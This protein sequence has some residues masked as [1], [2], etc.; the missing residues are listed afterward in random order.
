M[1]TALFIQLCVVKKIFNL[2]KILKEL[3]RNEIETFTSKKAISG[4]VKSNEDVV[5]YSF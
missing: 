4:L 5:L 3:G 2:T 1:C